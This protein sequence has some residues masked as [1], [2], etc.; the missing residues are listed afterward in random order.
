M[1]VLV[2]GVDRVVSKEKLV[3]LI[4]LAEEAHVLARAPAAAKGKVQVS[5][6]LASG[7]RGKE[8]YPLRVSSKN[9]T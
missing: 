2:D 5:S 4:A 6:P 9:M 7:K 3:H 8:A 1:T